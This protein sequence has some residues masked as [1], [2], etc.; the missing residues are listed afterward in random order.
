M[1]G[2]QKQV[3]STEQ[4]VSDRRTININ[5]KVGDTRFSPISRHGKASWSSELM[6]RCKLAIIVCI[7]GLDGESKVEG[8]PMALFQDKFKGKCCLTL[9]FKEENCICGFNFLDYSEPEIFI[10]ENEGWHY[11]QF[12]SSNRGLITFYFKRPDD[13]L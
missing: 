7:D 13:S 12:S 5:Q 4:P 8:K 11:V 6:D 10:S 2:D 1:I 3:L 9:K